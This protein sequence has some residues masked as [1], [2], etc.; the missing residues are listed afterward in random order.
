MRVV[1]LLS[2]PGSGKTALLEQLAGRLQRRGDVAMAVVVGDL[3]TDN[4]ARRLAA[5]GTPAVQITTG[6]ACHLEAAMVQRAVDEL[7]ARGQPLSELALL[8]IENV[9]NLVCPAAYDLG[10]GLRLVLLSV[11]EG[12]DKPLKYP[13]MFHSADVVLIAKSDLAE[14]V[15]FDRAAARAAV[16]RVAPHARLLEVSARSGDGMEALLELLL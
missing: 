16:A 1:N 12:E 8:V 5:T 13:A 7:E 3:A 15:G 2:S 11:T 6:Q 4:D 10:E 9:G 14:V